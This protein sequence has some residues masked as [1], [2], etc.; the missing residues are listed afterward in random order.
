MP[1]FLMTSLQRILPGIVCLGVLA[2][3]PA[4]AEVSYLDDTQLV[5]WGHNNLG[6]ANVPTGN[7]FTQIA[8]GLDHNVALR[9]DG[10]LVAW[11]RNDYGQADVPTGNDFTQVAAGAI[12][13]LA[14]KSD[15]SL[16]AWGNNYY[17]QTV[18]PAG[19]DFTQVAGGYAHSLALKSDGSLAA[20]GDDSNGLAGIPSG[21]DFTQVAAGA[22]H[23]LALKSD[24]SLAAWGLN[25]VGQTDVPDGFFLAIAAGNEH[26]LAIQA[27]LSYDDL[28]VSGSG[29]AALLQ[30]PI[31]VAGDA[32]IES[33][34]E[35]RGGLAGVAATFG[36]QFAG[37]RAFPESPFTVVD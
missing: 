33:M 1:N 36:A 11:G 9:S 37:G 16:A 31:D 30:R 8:A 3:T 34:M 26:N 19:N 22:Y 25:F 15:G 17:G 14:L 18:V 7:D 35:A 13:S 28:L 20:W 10:S 12:H 32:T 24:G 27:R 6:Q 23:S 5:G 21:N 29:A 4:R 2:A